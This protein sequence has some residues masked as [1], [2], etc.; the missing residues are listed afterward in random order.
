MRAAATFCRYSAS[1]DLRGSSRWRWSCLISEA[2]IFSTGWSVTARCKRTWL[3]VSLC[4]YSVR[5]LSCTHTTSCTPTFNQALFSSKASSREMPPS[6][7]VGRSLNCALGPRTHV[8]M[9]GTRL[10]RLTFLPHFPSRRCVSHGQEDPCWCNRTGGKLRHSRL[11]QSR[12]AL[13]GGRGRTLAAV[14]VRCRYVGS[15]SP[16]LRHALR[17]RAFSRG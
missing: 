5:W 2:A 11:R 15:R 6:G 9:R 4:N 13:M 3:A 14:R 12:S 1:C 7:S 10:L 17:V 8:S 16:A